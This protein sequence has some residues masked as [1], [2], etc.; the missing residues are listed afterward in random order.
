MRGGQGHQGLGP[1]VRDTLL[2]RA[3]CEAA[4]HRAVVPPIHLAT[5]YERDEQGRLEDYNYG[6]LGNPTR[7]LFERAFAEVEGGRTAFAFS[8]GMAASS[9]LLLTEPHSHVLLPQDLYHGNLM[10][11]KE[12]MPWLTFDTVDYSDKADVEKHI[13]QSKDSTRRLVLW[14]G[15]DV[16]QTV[17]KLTTE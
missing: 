13:L 12:L 1:L 9:A 5:T 17:L 8:S 2:S 11:I 6:R 7:S 15:A 10:L 4:Q 16:V 14:L 3:G